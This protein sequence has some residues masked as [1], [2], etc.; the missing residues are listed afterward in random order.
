MRLTNCQVHITLHYT[1]ASKFLDGSTFWYGLSEVVTQMLA[2]KR[3]Q[4]PLKQVL[5]LLGH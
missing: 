2:A 3:L 1:C 5:L 4:W